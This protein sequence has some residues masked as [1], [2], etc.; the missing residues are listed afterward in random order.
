MTAT[1]SSLRGPFASDPIAFKEMLDGGT[2][3]YP[4]CNGQAAL[5]GGAG[6]FV[7]SILAK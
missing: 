6:G 5:A 3:S 1:N 4:S 2:L 7:G